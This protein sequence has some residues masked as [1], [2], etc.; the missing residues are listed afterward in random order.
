MLFILKDVYVTYKEEQNPGI[1]DIIAL[2]K[3]NMGQQLSIKDN[4]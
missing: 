3:L 4:L 2:K 1:V